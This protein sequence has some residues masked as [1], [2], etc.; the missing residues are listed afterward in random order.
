MQIP[1]LNSS[2]VITIVDLQKTFAENQP[3]EIPGALMVKDTQDLA[4]PTN[5]MISRFKSAG[6]MALA[7]LEQHGLGHISFASSF[8]GKIPITQTGPED[9]KA[10][11]TY[12]EVKNWTPERNGISP[13]A[14]FTLKELQAYMKIRG[15]EAMWPD[16]ATP[17][18]ESE[19]ITGFDQSQL[20]EIFVKGDD[21]AEHTYS[22]FDAK[23]T[24]GINLADYMRSKNIKRNFVTSLATDFCVKNTAIDSVRQGFK[25]YLIQG[26][27]RSVYPENEEAQLKEMQ[28]NGVIIIP[29]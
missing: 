4:I 2:D 18:Y 10:F 8:I 1:T 19:F 9:P 3:D 5:E 22:A 24:Q 27:S 16:H 26:L 21:I 28:N 11:I 17:G 6:G 20:N 15:V 29:K 23:N 7:S 12:D 25:T 13:S 14:R